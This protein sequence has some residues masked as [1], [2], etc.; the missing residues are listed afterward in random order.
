MRAYP[1]DEDQGEEECGSDQKCQTKHTSVHLVVVTQ[2]KLNDCQQ[3]QSDAV[4][5]DDGGNLRG[6]IQSF[7]PDI[8]C[9]EGHQYG[10]QLQEPLVGV[11]DG[12][13]HYSTIIHTHKDRIGIGDPSGLETE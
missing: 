8:A 1:W 4:D 11:R 13:P 7:D 2:G 12:K 3:S 5:V 9:V 6:V 10:H